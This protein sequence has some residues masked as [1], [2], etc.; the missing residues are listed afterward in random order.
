[1]KIALDTN[2]YVDF[3]RG[4][5]EAVEAVAQA[6]RVFMPFEV[7]AE[8][9]AGFQ[10]GVRSKQNERALVRFLDSPRVRL[11][12]P[13]EQTTHHYAALFAQ[14]RTQ[15]TPIPTNDIWIAAL[16]IQHGLTLVDRD[17]HFD[18]LAQLSRL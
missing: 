14:L 4:V 13:D 5:L 2:R 10:V 3:C 12:L 16:V 1:M 17:R 11:L 15:A 8:L 6:E 7:L 9:G 18:Q